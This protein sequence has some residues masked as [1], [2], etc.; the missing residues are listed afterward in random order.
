MTWVPIVNK[1]F[2]ASEFHD[3]VASLQLSAALWKPQFIVHHNTAS[4]TRQ[5][6]EGYKNRPDPISDEQWLNNLA[7]FYQ[8]KGWQA[9]PHLF[10]V[11]D[12]INV[13]T[14]LT[15]RGTHT[16]SWNYIS[17]GIEMVGDYMTEELQGDILDMAVAASA[18]LHFFGGIDP[19]PYHVG[20]TGLHFHKEDPR[21][22][23][24]DCPGKNVLKEPF[25]ELVVDRLD[26]M[27]GHPD[28]RDS[29]VAALPQP[30][31]EV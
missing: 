31:A 30:A 24:Q 14:P 8:G 20:A 7:A 25:V 12:G 5:Q 13:F 11:P 10:V 18:T 29:A 19:L 23:H 3:Y 6:Y 27:R 26:A 15:H 1:K 9:G 17:W 2:S 16:P 21:T 22:T 28:N 4:P